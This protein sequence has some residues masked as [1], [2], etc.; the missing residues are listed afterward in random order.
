MR[1]KEERTFLKQAEGYFKAENYEKAK[2]YYEEY[3]KTN[4][5]APN[6]KQQLICNKLGENYYELG[7]LQQAKELYNKS[8]EICKSVLRRATL[9]HS[10]SHTTISH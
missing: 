5:T 9:I 10:N 4:K 3:I 1:N 8:L 2:R 6:K 7:D